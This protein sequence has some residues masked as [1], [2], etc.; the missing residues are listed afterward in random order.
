MS[1]SESTWH[2]PPEVQAAQEATRG[3]ETHDASRSFDSDDDSDDSENADEQVPG[4]QANEQAAQEHRAAVAIQAISRGRKARR[5][6]VEQAARQTDAAVAIQAISRGRK[7][8]RRNRPDAGMPSL[9]AT[10]KGTAG[11]TASPYTGIDDIAVF[12]ALSSGGASAV[13]ALAEACVSRA[14]AEVRARV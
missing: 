4:K 6:E 14:I 11:E 3:D 5:Q 8:R 7:A 1:T 2:L 10:L 12:K 13:A 9:H